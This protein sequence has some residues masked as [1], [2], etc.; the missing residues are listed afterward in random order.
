M[1]KNP[2]ESFLFLSSGEVY[3]AID[4]VHIPT[5]EKEYGFID[6]TDVRSC[7]G[8]SKRMGETMCISYF[9]QFN[10]P[11]KIVRPFHTYGPGMQLDDGR[12]FADFVSD[13][14]NGKDIVMKSDGSAIRAFCILRFLMPH[15]MLII[16]WFLIIISIVS[17]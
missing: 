12:V 10:I 16:T 6:P 14:V 13:I 1:L 3:G 17:I 9:H 8:E 2:V 5:G 15:V 4:S 7:Y 11:S